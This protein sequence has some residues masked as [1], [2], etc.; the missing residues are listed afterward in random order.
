VPILR[1][2]GT[3]ISFSIGAAGGIFAPALSA[4]ASIGSAISGLL[5]LSPS[6]TNL[7]I[8]CGMTGFLTG[9]TRSPFTSSILVLEMTNSHDIIFYIML[10]ALS[11]NLISGFITRHSFYDELKVNYISEIHHSEVQE[12]EAIKIKKDET[13]EENGSK[14]IIE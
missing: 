14:Q 5:H 8:L 12:A 4:G 6:E 13:G 1:L 10:T 3:I 11:A 7:V 9:I 2:I